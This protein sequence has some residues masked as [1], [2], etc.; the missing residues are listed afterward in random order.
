MRNRRKRVRISS[1][2]AFRAQK[3]RGLKRCISELKVLHAEATSIL[4]DLL[5]NPTAAIVRDLCARFH[6]LQAYFS[7]RYHEARTLALSVVGSL[8]TSRSFLQFSLP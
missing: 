3:L 8:E 2:G 5:I 6:I 7:I 1:P 4:T